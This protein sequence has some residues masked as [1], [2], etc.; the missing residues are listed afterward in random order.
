MNINII[1]DFQSMTIEELRK[2]LI[3]QSLTIDELEA[4]NK[5]TEML[6]KVAKLD[7]NS[8]HKVWIALVAYAIYKL[9]CMNN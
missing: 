1:A 5:G 7:S 4:Y 2:W 3:S 9:K 6:D 8:S